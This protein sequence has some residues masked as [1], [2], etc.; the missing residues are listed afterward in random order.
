M[1]ALLG[2]LYLLLLLEHS[3]RDLKCFVMNLLESVRTEYLYVRFGVFAVN[4]SDFTLSLLHVKV[5]EQDV[6]SAAA[7][8]GLVRLY[9]VLNLH[10][11]SGVILHVF[12][13]KYCDSTACT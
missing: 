8:L 2:L 12:A 5:S 6:D 11:S 4:H 3:C 1:G 9:F 10:V 13:W 7:S